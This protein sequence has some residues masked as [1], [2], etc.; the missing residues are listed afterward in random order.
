MNYSYLARHQI[1]LRSHEECGGNMSP[2]HKTLSSRAWRKASV[3][4]CNV[5]Q[6]WRNCTTDWLRTIPQTPS[7]SCPSFR[8]GLPGRRTPSP[9]YLLRTAHREV[10]GL[11]CNFYHFIISH[12]E[13]S[14]SCGW[15]RPN[16]STSDS[17]PHSCFVLEALP[18]PK[19]LA[20]VPWNQS[21]TTGY[22]FCHFNYGRAEGNN[23]AVDE[24]LWDVNT[25][26]LKPIKC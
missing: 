9:P 26:I 6:Q 16:P 21:D 15:S 5:E 22:Q 19:S 23:C 20:Y 24:W 11:E 18:R 7:V 17:S 14:D 10:Q 13:L 1:Q 2:N 4:L 12:T 25:L 3:V 8:P